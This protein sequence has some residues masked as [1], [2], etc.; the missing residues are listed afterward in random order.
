M[1]IHITEIGR[2]RFVCGLFWQSLSRRHELR[3]EATELGRQL[4]F[5][6]MVLRIDRGAAT[7]GFA[8]RSEGARPGL[9]SL[10]AMVSKTI[11][12][13]GAYYDDRQQQA[14]NWL[15]A[16]R[17]P[18]GMWAYFAVRDGVFLPNGDWVGSREKVFER[19]HADYA[20]GGWNVVIG[21]PEMESHGYHNF[22]PRQIDDLFPQRNGKRRIHRWWGL[23]P[24]RNNTARPLVLGAAVA[25]AMLLVGGGVAY[26]MHQ[27][28]LSEEL[29][30]ETQARVHGPRVD[31]PPSLPHP[32]ATQPDPLAFADGCLNAFTQMSAGGWALTEF[33]C[34]LDGAAYAW[35]RNGSTASYLLA[36]QPAAQ[37]DASGNRASLKVPVRFA[38]GADDVLGGESV[39]VG[40]LSL[41]Q[42]LDRTATLDLQRPPVVAPPGRVPGAPFGLGAHEPPRPTWKTWTIKVNLGGVSP[43]RVAASLSR[44]GVR[45][46]RLTFVDGQWSLQ[47]DVYVQQ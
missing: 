9:S 38:S 27:R 37:L 13:E 29:L 41:F 15:G 5:D 22:Y 2:H 34:T 42:S 31:S 20:L 23:Q 45:L 32:W 24:V 33:D 6:L 10:G 25:G 19:L 8:N 30:V 43:R 36:E 14:P 44:P 26:R 12:V 17:L 16:F 28:A 39:R 35:S 46:E 7:V 40:V 3:R 18:D 21:E 4:K 1:A 11:A 47:G